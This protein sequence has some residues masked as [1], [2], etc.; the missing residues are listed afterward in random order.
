MVGKRKGK[1]R[2]RRGEKEGYQGDGRNG[3]SAEQKRRDKEEEKEGYKGERRMKGIIG[4]GEGEKRK[5]NQ[6]KGYK[7]EG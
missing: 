3:K 2:E 4:R 7:G 6:R 1:G 5:G